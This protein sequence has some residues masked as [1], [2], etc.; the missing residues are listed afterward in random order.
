M[1]HGAA[2]HETSRA[3]VVAAKSRFG[4]PMRRASMR[5]HKLGGEPALRSGAARV[6]LDAL[7]D[8]TPPRTIASQK[9]AP[10]GCSG[11]QTFAARIHGPVLLHHAKLL[12][13]SRTLVRE[14][15]PLRDTAVVLRATY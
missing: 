2:D 8:I 5:Q 15:L 12:Q 6:S 1:L 14:K 3:R 10:E 13:P 7:V 4:T 9:S 11:R